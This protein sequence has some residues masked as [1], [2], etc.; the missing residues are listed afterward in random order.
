MHVKWELPNKWEKQ[1]QTQVLEYSASREYTIQADIVEYDGNHMTKPGFDLILGSNTMKELG[2]VLDFWTKEISIDDSLPMRDIN[3]LRSKA[4]A[5]KAW[6]ANNS[7]YTKAQPKSH[8][9]C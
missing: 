6:V 7:I 9:A 3:N 5:D 2:I 8:K 1:D 4:A